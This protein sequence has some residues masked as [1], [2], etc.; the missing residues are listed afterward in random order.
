MQEYSSQ[1]H[2]M[3]GAQSDDTHLQVAVC[4]Q[5]SAWFNYFHQL[6]TKDDV[7]PLFTTADIKQTEQQLLSDHNS[8]FVG[9]VIDRLYQRTKQLQKEHKINFREIEADDPDASFQA[10][11][12]KLHNMRVDNLVFAGKWQE[13]KTK[14]FQGIDNANYKKWKDLYYL[15]YDGIPDRFRIHVW[16][17]FLKVKV[18]EFEEC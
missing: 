12:I 16:K 11:E 14:S 18:V 7:R 2:R 3:C 15:V 6:W 9:E 1:L 8:S 5:T 4:Y 10:Q 17:E 13:E